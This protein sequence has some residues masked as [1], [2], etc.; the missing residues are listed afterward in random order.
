M[1]V[2]VVDYVVARLM[3]W[4]IVVAF[5]W[6]LLPL[7]V[8]CRF[9]IVGLRSY[10][11]IAG[12]VTLVDLIYG[13]LIAWLLLPVTFVD[14]VGLPCRLLRLYLVVTLLIGTLPLRFGSCWLIAVGDL[15]TLAVDWLIALLRYSDW[16]QLLIEGR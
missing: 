16:L 9:L 13:W 8:D 2:V 10:L 14:S 1:I 4:L 12:A 6:F 3:I 7:P 11:L 15:I 5:G